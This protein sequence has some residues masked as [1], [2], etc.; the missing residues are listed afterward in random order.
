MQFCC[1]TSVAHDRVG[2]HVDGEDRGQLADAG[3]YPAPAMVKVKA[4]RTQRLTTWYHGVSDNETRDERGR[5]MVVG[6]LFMAW[7]KVVP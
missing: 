7:L 2:G 1:V 5:V 4:R 6:V 3:F